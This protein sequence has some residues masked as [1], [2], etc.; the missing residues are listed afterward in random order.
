MHGSWIIYKI[1]FLGREALKLGIQRI[2][3]AF[4]YFIEAYGLS[5]P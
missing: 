3:V 1:F 4:E 5:V 2:S